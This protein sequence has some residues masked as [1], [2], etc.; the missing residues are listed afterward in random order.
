MRA[1]L[2]FY[3]MSDVP[4]RS[5]RHGL[6]RAVV[7][8]NTSDMSIAK[9]VRVSIVNAVARAYRDLSGMDPNADLPINVVEPLPWTVE[10]PKREG[11]GDL[12]TNAAL[13]LAK[14][15]GKPPDVIA[16]AIGDWLDPEVFRY[17]IAGPGFLNLTLQPGAFHADLLDVLRAGSGWGRRPAGTGERINLEFV[18]ANPTGPVTVASGRNAVLGDVLARVLQ[19]QG[20]QVT[21][22]YYI[23]DRGSQVFKLGGSIRRTAR[24]M[25]EGGNEDDPEVEYR[26][27]YMIELTD[28]LRSHDA[29]FSSTS[30]ERQAHVAAYRL[31]HGI[32][33]S[34]TLPGIRPSLAA[35][36][37]HF[38]VWFSEKSLF[39]SGM[40][41]DTLER[42][43]AAGRIEESDGAAVYRPEDLPIAAHPADRGQTPAAPLVYKVAGLQNGERVLRKTNGEWTYFASD[44]AYCAD[45]IARGYDR[46][47]LVVGADHHGYVPWIE[48]VLQLLGFQGAFNVLLYQLVTIL[49]DGVP[50]KMSKRAGNIVTI[51][52]VM[53]EIDEAMD[54]RGAGADALR[55]SLLVRSPNTAVEFDVEQAKKRSLDNP[56]F[57]IQY[58]YARLC[59]IQ[60]KAGA[61]GFHPSTRDLSGLCLKSELSLI[62]LLG[63]FPDVL[64]RAARLLEPHRLATYL[65]N[66]ARTFHGYYTETRKDPILPLES[67]MAQ[68]GWRDTWN[69]ARTEARLSLVEAVRVIYKSALNLVGITAPEQMN[70]LDE[71]GYRAS[72][73]PSEHHLDATTA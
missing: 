63:E 65:H 3:M 10:R 7:L 4:T 11:Q 18:S 50:V 20:H 59:G 38:D 69:E 73:D 13:V 68:P 72:L 5:A 60:R 29:S 1:R 49:K 36:G 53:D 30:E 61:L 39:D 48:D 57:Y 12:A 28:W 2:V 51:D 40:F 23:N 56:V 14:P 58:G 62:Q 26:G 55:Y 54:R 37:V 31:V 6:A 35:L 22:E 25:L 45:K 70:R 66:L 16:K 32:P 21:R 17:E 47:I 19:A 15:L 9:R 27:P 44:A 41:R 42:I 46:L 52:E 24:V 64:D 71:D 33:G 67:T 43:E 8:D 34:K